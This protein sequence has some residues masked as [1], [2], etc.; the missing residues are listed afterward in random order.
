MAI[1]FSNY[2]GWIASVYVDLNVRPDAEVRMM[3]LSVTTKSFSVGINAF[4]VLII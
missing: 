3:T 4:F 1:H 2:T